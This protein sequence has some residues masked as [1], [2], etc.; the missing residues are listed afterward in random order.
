MKARYILLFLTFAFLLAFA[1]SNLIFGPYLNKT[2]AQIMVLKA[3]NKLPI[4]AKHFAYRGNGWVEFELDG[5]MR[6]YCIRTDVIIN[7]ED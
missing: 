7:Y 1:L 2:E 4:D 5:K 3:E 6:M